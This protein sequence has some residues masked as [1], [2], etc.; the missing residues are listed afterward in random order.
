MNFKAYKL[1]ALL[2]ALL[3]F[4]LCNNIDSASIKRVRKEILEEDVDAEP[5]IDPNPVNLNASANSFKFNS[6]VVLMWEKCG[7]EA[8]TRLTQI[9]KSKYSSNSELVFSFNPS[10]NVISQELV[11]AKNASI[12]QKKVLKLPRVTS[13]L[14]FFV[15]KEPGKVK[16]SFFSVF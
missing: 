16:Y 15:F 10:T 9:F 2:F 7:L 3:D 12:S 5:N 1:L 14:I 13:G 6:S 11:N 8:R 4:S